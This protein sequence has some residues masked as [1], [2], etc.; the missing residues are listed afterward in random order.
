MYK[1]SVFRHVA[2]RIKLATLLPANPRSLHSA[3]GQVANVSSRRVRICCCVRLC[4]RPAKEPAAAEQQ[5]ESLFE[6]LVGAREQDR[7]QSGA[8][9][10]SLC[11]S[12]KGFEE[13]HWSVSVKKLFIALALMFSCLLASDAFAAVTFKRF[14]HCGKGLVTVKTCECHARHSRIWHYCHAGEYCQTDGSCHK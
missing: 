6:H 9:L 8:L 11:H 13:K 3:D 4:A 2:L 12:M 5:T 10:R 14:Q 1:G 7:R